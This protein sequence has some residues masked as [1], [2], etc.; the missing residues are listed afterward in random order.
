[1]KLLDKL[2]PHKYEVALVVLVATFICGMGVINSLFLSKS[3]KAQSFTAAD[4]WIG[5][6]LSLILITA[7]IWCAARKR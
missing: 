2:I 1:M 4:I 5:I 3:E 6:A 7:P